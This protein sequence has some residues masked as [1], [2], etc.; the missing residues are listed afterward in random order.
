MLSTTATIKSESAILF[1]DS[2]SNSIK[3][4]DLTLTKIITLD[5]HSTHLLKR[6]MFILDTVTIMDFEVGLR[7]DL[8]C[9]YR[10]L[11][12]ITQ[13][14]PRRVEFLSNLVAKVGGF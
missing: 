9:S 11:W 12:L 6:E 14:L 5:L 4:Q 7:I 8:N 10:N 2:W 3:V 1:S 13:V